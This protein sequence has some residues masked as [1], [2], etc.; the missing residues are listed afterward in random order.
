MK[1]LCLFF[2]VFVFICVSFPVIA[3]DSVVLDEIVVTGKSQE[4][5]ES[6]VQTIPLVQKGVISVP[7]VLKNESGIDIKRRSILTPGNNQIKIR[8]LDE[9]RS[10]IMIDGRSLNGTGVMGGYFVDWSSLSLM[11]FQTIEISKGAFSAKHGN[12]LG[13]TIDMKSALPEKGAHF[14]LYSGY[15]KYQTYIT[16]GS[17]TYLTDQYHA[18]FMAAH[19]QTDG[20]LRNSEAQRDDFSMGLLL[21]LTDQEIKLNV[22]YS[23]GDFNMPVENNVSNTTY[24]SSYPESI[25]T[26]L[27]GPGIKFINGHG[28]GDDSFFNKKR[29][30]M[31]FSYLLLKPD[32]S[33]T[34]KVYFNN[35]ERMETLF[36]WLDGQKILQRESTP[37]RSWGW[38]SDM[39]KQMGEHQFGCGLSGNYLGYGGTDYTFTDN[40]YYK[41]LSD[42]RDEWDGTKHHGI[43]IDDHWQLS[44]DLEVYAGLR[45]ELYNGNRTA[46][47][48]QAYTNGKPSNFVLHDVEFDESAI[49]PKLSIIYSP[50]PSLSIHGRV[51]RATRF[52]DNPAF[53][54]YYGGYQPEIDPKTDVVRKELAY[55]DAMQ[56]E[57][58]FLYKFEKKFSIHTNIYNYEIDDY[59]RWIFGYAPSRL[60]YNIDSVDLYGIELEFDGKLTDTLSFFSN[61]TYQKSKKHGDVM[62]ASMG[63]D[64]SLSELP[65]K[66]CA[67]GLRYVF[68]DKIKTEINMRWVDKTY[69]P[70][71]TDAEPDGIP[72]GKDLVLKELDDF[73]TIDFFLKI[74]MKLKQ[75]DGM[76]TL[77]VEN[78]FDE[79]Y[80]EEYGFPALGQTAGIYLEMRY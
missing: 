3:E 36:D 50:M 64:D 58:G 12:T 4:D 59:I 51:A 47:T 18:S 66:K 24:S 8:G 49:L 77:A 15:K 72:V 19:N 28:H 73:M 54:W 17:A 33:F 31:D 23:D 76:F 6:S 25:G 22:R 30:E 65:E 70:Y 42:G 9:R 45:Y 11:D 71:G 67:A 14:K 57:V 68:N 10:K 5:T 69:I 21:F 32:V 26:Y 37:D 48:A 43:Y 41:P 2:Y 55:E 46:E 61:F 29:M 53:Y 38:R 74:P 27:T 39:E 34:T 80:Q 7:D 63:L 35:E 1:S 56:Y 75:L 62:D 40:K 79:S 52:P 78:L 20:H 44:K 16:G 13:G 60:V